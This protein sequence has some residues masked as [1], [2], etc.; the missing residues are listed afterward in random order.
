MLQGYGPKCGRALGHGI[1]QSDIDEIL[2]VH[3]QYRAKI[4]NGQERRGKP[5]PQPPAADM[6]LMVS[7]KTN[8][9][10]QK[11]KQ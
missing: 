11:N 3:N 2:Q 10:I 4:A 7:L 5:G 8:K 9:Y 1:T 6:Q